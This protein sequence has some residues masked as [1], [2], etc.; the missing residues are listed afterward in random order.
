MEK[1][2]KKITEKL[3]N[4]IRSN[5][6]IQQSDNVIKVL[7]LLKLITLIDRNRNE[8]EIKFIQNFIRNNNPIDY[9]SESLFNCILANSLILDFGSIGQIEAALEYSSI[10]YEIKDANPNSVNGVLLNCVFEDDNDKNE[11][12]SLNFKIPMFE[13][14]IIKMINDVLA[15]IEM[16]SK[17]GTCEVEY[18]PVF[19]SKI[20]G[21]AI[22]AMRLYDLE[23]VMRSL[24]ALN[25]LECKESL[26]I[27][28]GLD[29]I[30]HQQCTDGSFGDFE[31]AFSEVKNEANGEIT[32]LQIKLETA[33]QVLWTLYELTKDKNNLISRIFNSHKHF[34]Q[35]KT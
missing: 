27:Q 24:R 3:Y 25:Y 7:A 6:G 10:L 28:T 1:S 12:S 26:A 4:W 8:D 13:L 30:L 31:T 34:N 19:N 2:I 20:E 18:N 35:I 9:R 16:K 33:I 23:L 15:Q 17:F 29:F 14:D 11:I 21:M 32:I 22:H 5:N